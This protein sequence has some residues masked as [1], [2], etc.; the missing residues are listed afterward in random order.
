MKNTEPITAR[1]LLI[2]EL[3][4]H[5]F[6]SGVNETLDRE[7]PGYYSNPTLVFDYSIEKM[8]EDQYRRVGYP[9]H[10][11]YYEVKMFFGE[12]RS[13]YVKLFMCVDVNRYNKRLLSFAHI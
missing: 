8:T 3:D 5:G 1:E 11:E 10:D 9:D 12:D 7:T 6:S 13:S 4:L 2:N